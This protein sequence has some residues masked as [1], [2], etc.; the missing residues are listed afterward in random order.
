MSGGET[1]TTTVGG[2]DPDHH[3]GNYNAGLDNPAPTVPGPPPAPLGPGP[4][5]PQ[6][7]GGPWGAGGPQPKDLLDC[8]FDGDPESLSF[9]VVQV[10]KF[11]ERWAHLFP[12]DEQL[13]DFISTRLRG[14]TSSWYVQLHDLNAGELVDVDVDAFM[15]ALRERFEDRAAAEKAEAFLRTFRQGRLSVRE[16][17][18]EFRRQ[19]VK[20]RDWTDLVLAQQY[21]LGLT[22]EI[23]NN[24]MSALHIPCDSSRSPHSTWRFLTARLMQGLP[25]IFQ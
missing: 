9:F 2:D 14:I 18:M 5:L 21:R 23:R 20:I 16:Y 13:V 24:V 12:D 4:V 7:F 11:V 22:A 19:A 3:A 8:T 10:A 25:D 17:S 6:V 15:W 1:P